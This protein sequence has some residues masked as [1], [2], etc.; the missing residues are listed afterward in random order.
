MKK[1]K[2]CKLDKE[3]VYRCS[4]CEECKPLASKER[5]KRY[6]ARNPERVKAWNNDPEHLAKVQEILKTPR[7]R[8]SQQKHA[9]KIR[10]IPFLFTFDDWWAKWQPYW[11][12]RGKAS[13]QYCMA[14]KGDVGPY[15]KDNVVIATVRENA[16]RLI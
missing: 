14:R 4:L 2:R 13:D 3:I 7:G 12:K 16:A 5:F 8:F 10:N 15:S 1:C 9:A 11:S 6:H